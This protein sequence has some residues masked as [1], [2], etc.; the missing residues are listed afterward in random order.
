MEAE[1]LKQKHL[2]N[3]GGLGVL[4]DM[5]E[6]AGQKVMSLGPH[7]RPYVRDAVDQAKEVVEDVWTQV[8]PKT[9]GEKMVHE[10]KERIAKG[11]HGVPL[12]GMSIISN[13]FMS[14]LVMLRLEHEAWAGGAAETPPRRSKPS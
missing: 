3:L 1:W 6:A 8:V 13:P 5:A 11:G 2:G 9:P 7:G 4:G 10:E 12:S 14:R